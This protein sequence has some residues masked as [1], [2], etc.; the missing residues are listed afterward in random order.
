LLKKNKK[1]YSFKLH[2]LEAVGFV[3]SR[4]Q[5]WHKVNA[6]ANT[7]K[8][9]KVLPATTIQTGRASSEGQSSQRNVPSTTKATPE[10]YIVTFRPYM[11]AVI[12][13]VRYISPSAKR[14][15]PINTNMVVAAEDNMVSGSNSGSTYKE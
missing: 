10:N 7:A 12:I 9:S 3:S 13:Q 2:L 1:I 5:W 6:M 14:R 8:T 4:S 15:A 11:C